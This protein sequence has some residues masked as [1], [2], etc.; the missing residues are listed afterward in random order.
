MLYTYLPVGVKMVQFSAVILDL[1]QIESTVL[2][3]N[4]KLGMSF[5][6]SDYITHNFG[7]AVNFIKFRRCIIQQVNALN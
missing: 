2:D 5:H 1:R 4:E 6:P 3:I 7:D